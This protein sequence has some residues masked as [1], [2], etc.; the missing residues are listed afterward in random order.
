MHHICI[1]GKGDIAYIEFDAIEQVIHVN[2]FYFF[3][4]GVQ[5][6]FETSLPLSIPS[7]YFSTLF[8]YMVC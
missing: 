6:S 2:C 7:L 3:N 4:R 1:F 8:F 5:E